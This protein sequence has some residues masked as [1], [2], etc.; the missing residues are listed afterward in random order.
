M[1]RNLDSVAKNDA[2]EKASLSSIEAMKK[3]YESKIV[4]L[5]AEN[6]KI[7]SEL[8]ESKSKAIDLEYSWKSEKS[9]NEAKAK[10]IERLQNELK[11][12]EK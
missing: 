10:E 7:D 12:K 4:T 8:K 3:E 9:A 1:R 2:K 5:E 11:R 6:K